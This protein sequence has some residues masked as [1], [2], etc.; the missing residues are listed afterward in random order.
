MSDGRS[1]V[2]REAGGT[3]RVY[4][5]KT[6]DCHEQGTNQRQ[7]IPHLLCN[8]IDAY[9]IVLS[10]YHFL[11][12]LLSLFYRSFTKTTFPKTYTRTQE[13]SILCH[14]N[15]FITFDKFLRALKRLMLRGLIPKLSDPCLELGLAYIKLRTKH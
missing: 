15:K 4:G 8:L 3:Q 7:N 13:L 6:K 9:F 14:P 10:L 12:F 5:Q 2:S 1:D 11:P